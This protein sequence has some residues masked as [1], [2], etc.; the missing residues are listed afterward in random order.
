MEEVGLVV[1]A[2]GVVYFHAGAGTGGVEG[3]EVAAAVELSGTEAGLALE[4]DAR[5]F[6]AVGT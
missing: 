1:V 4:L 6:E 5:A 3:R 2:G